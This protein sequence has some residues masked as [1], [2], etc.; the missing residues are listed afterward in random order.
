M[1]EEFLHSTN[2]MRM[3]CL[4]LGAPLGA[5]DKAGS[6]V[7]QNIMV[8]RAYVEVVLYLIVTGKQRE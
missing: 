4:V 8:A 2:M 6:M 1:K 7:R 3:I 5:G